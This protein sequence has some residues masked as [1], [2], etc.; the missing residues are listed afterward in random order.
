MTINGEIHTTLTADE[1]TLITAMCYTYTESMKKYNE[2]SE[3]IGK[4]N[5]LINRLGSEL[6]SYP[7]NNFVLTPKEKRRIKKSNERKDLIVLK[8]KKPFKTFPSYSCITKYIKEE[9]NLTLEND[10]K[11]MERYTIS[12][13]SNLQRFWYVNIMKL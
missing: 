9:L 12:R 1:T 6:Y 4:A 11:K 10:T 7:K 8:D 3:N 2:Y 5:A 13:M